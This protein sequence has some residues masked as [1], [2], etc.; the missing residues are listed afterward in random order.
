MK[1]YKKVVTR[2]FSFCHFQNLKSSI[3]CSTWSFRWDMNLFPVY[4]C[5]ILLMSLLLSLWSVTTF[6]TLFA[7]L[8]Q[9]QMGAGNLP[10]SICILVAKRWGYYTKVVMNVTRVLKYFLHCE[11]NV[12]CLLLINLEPFMAELSM[13]YPT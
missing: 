2:T 4:N 8:D 6:N 13:L 3:N 5:F 10:F 11:G 9:E 7:R 12:I 1:P